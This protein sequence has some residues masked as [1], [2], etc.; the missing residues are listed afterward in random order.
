M[1]GLNAL[2]DF[3]ECEIRVDFQLV[4]GVRW[5]SIVDDIRSFEMCALSVGHVVDGEIGNNVWMTSVWPHREILK[6]FF[7]YLFAISIFDES[8]GH[9]GKARA[10]HLIDIRGGGRRGLCLGVD[11]I[12]SDSGMKSILRMNAAD[13]NHRQ[14][15]TKDSS[16]L[17][18]GTE[19]FI[20]SI[21]QHSNGGIVIRL[22]NKS[23]SHNWINNNWLKN[24]CNG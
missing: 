23:L 1:V 4:L 18:F 14:S 9:F 21:E 6:Y 16:K 2:Y 15:H 3:S 10:E 8:Q 12:I 24:E 20:S 22:L 7:F 13:F 17:S 19:N 5:Y 11:E